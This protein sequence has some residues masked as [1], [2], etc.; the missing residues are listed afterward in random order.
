MNEWTNQ[1]TNDEKEKCAISCMAE[2]WIPKDDNLLQEKEADNN[3]NGNG[4]HTPYTKT[5]YLQQ[6]FAVEQCRVLLR[7]M[8]NG[9][10]SLSLLF[11]LSISRCIIV[12]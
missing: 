2:W 8:E 6:K 4:W 12:N 7:T 9:V 5:I 3:F 10:L 1:P 11:L